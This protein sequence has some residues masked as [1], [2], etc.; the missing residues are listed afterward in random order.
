M[1][2]TMEWWAIPVLLCLVG[3]AAS[4]VSYVIDGRSSNGSILRGCVGDL[5]CFACWVAAAG[6]CVGRWLA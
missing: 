2:I 4:V 5:I 1:T 6:I 3:I